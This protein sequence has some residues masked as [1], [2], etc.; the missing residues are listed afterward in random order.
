[1]K[2]VI[3]EPLGVDEEKLMA[4]AKEALGS[5]VEIVY[6]PTRT[7]DTK[8]LI[9]RG[10]DADIIAVSNLPLNSEVIDG[11]KKLKLL[12]VAFTG[13]D[14]IAMMR[15]RKMVLQYVIA[16]AIRQPPWQ[17]SSLVC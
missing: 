1:M 13:V 11:C 16:P 2:L 6:Y 9:E 12:S 15:V 14:H 7:T 8:D 3:I 17:T 10:K 5:R 4:M